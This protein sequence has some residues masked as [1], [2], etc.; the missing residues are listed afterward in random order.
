L[1][2]V[3]GF[4]A[5][6]RPVT[7]DIATGFLL[8]L[9][10]LIAGLLSAIAGFANRGWHS[11]WLDFAIGLLCI[12]LGAMVL[13]DPFAGAVS[14]VWVI[15]IWVIMSGILEIFAAYKLTFSR[16]WLALLG[17]L[18]LLL[19]V[20]LLMAGPVTGLLFLALIVGVSFTVR[21][22]SLMRFGWSLRRALRRSAR[23]T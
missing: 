15:S 4:L 19:G 20:I 18:N 12:V 3:I 1:L 8:G 13:R 2:V 17:L 14:L 6:I 23:P 21:G 16:G 22:V 5:I 9:L 7:A 11:R 10:L